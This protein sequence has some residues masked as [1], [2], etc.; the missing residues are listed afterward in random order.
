MLISLGGG[1]GLEDVH[2]FGDEVGEVHG[3]WVDG[4]VG[5]AELGLDVGWDDFED[6]GGG[7]FE[8]VTEQLV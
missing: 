7:C 3:A 5:T 4:L 1:L 2:D 6:L 8:L